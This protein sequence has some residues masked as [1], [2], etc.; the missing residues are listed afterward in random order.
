MNVLIFDPSLV[1]DIRYQERIVQIFDSIADS[2]V[3][4]VTGIIQVAWHARHF[5]PDIIVFDWV[6]DSKQLKNLVRMLQRIK[7]DVGMFHLDGGGVVAVASPC[8]SLKEMVV[9]PWLY[10]IA[11][12]WSFARCAPVLEQ[13]S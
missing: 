8:G 6:C 1:P 7:P 12:Q 2:S 3:R 5:R 10:K 13:L 11:S 9:P 4:F